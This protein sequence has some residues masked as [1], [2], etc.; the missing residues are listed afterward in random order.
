MR[1]LAIR[2]FFLLFLSAI[3]LRLFYW[4]V[5]QAQF[6]QSQADNQH[7]TDTKVDATR[8]NILFSD[9][10]ILISSKPVFSLYGLPKAMPASQKVDIAYSLAKIVLDGTTSETKTYATELVNKLSQDLYWVLLRKNVS[11]EQKKKIEGLDLPGLGFEQ[12]SSRFYPEGSSSAHLLGFVGS[13]A[14]GASKGY[15]GLEGYYDGELKGLP[16]LIRHEKDALGLPI[17]IGDFSAVEAVDGKDLILNIDRSVQFIVEKSLKAGMEKY[18]AKKGSV[19]VMDPSSGAVLALAAFPNYDPISYFDYPKEYLKNPVV[20]DQYEPGSTFKV[21]AMA[22]AIDDGAV[23]PDDKCDI[24][25]GSISLG[26][27]TIRTWNNR[28]FP[29]TNLKEIIVH[30]DN[31]GMVYVAKKLGLDK[32]YSYLNNFGFGTQ[33]NI[34]LQDE[35]V[36]DIRPKK[37]WREIDLA[38]ASFGQGIAVT[39]MQMVAAVGALANGGNLME[40]HV[41]REVQSD[42]NT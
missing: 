7:F 6:L 35:T 25:A 32:F 12:E 19:V 40:P 5:V 29:D 10:S 9:G 14:K 18:G 20:A 24:C 8:G 27:F 34:D 23:K 41:V 3:I 39:E 31:T 22:A 38:T 15:F 37:E 30:S 16:G 33:T 42:K 21:L 1:I 28:Y 2:T 11:L 17:L 36:P 26:G 4:Q 13:D